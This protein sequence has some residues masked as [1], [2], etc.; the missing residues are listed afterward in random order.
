MRCWLPVGGSIIVQ[1]KSRSVAKVGDGIV[2]QTGAKTEQLAEDAKQTQCL[3]AD[4]PRCRAG[5]PANF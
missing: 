2:G 1:R 5:D 4:C 3:P